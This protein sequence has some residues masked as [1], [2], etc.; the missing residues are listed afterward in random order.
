MRAEAV[1][2]AKGE[3]VGVA[4]DQSR[5]HLERLRTAVAGAVAD[6]RDSMEVMVVD[7]CG[8]FEVRVGGPSGALRLSFDRGAHPAFVRSVVR[9]TVDR[10]RVGDTTALSR[11]RE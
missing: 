2:Q 6:A 4:A 9:R 7:G 11:V 8:E 5:A 1:V 3:R 10:Y